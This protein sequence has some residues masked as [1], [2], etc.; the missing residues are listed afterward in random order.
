M[1]LKARLTGVL[2][3]VFLLSA[4]GGDLDD[5]VLTGIASLGATFL[6]AFNADL[7]SEPVDAQSVNLAVDLTAEPFNP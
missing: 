3:S 5:D 1:K 7:N 4:C 6:A 2:S